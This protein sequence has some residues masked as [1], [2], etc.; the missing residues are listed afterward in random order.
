MMTTMTIEQALI[1]AVEAHK[2]R[3]LQEAE[4]LYRAIL[5]NQPNQ[6]DANHNLGILAVQTGHAHSALSYLK[7]ALEANPSQGQFWIDYID[8]LNRT[9]QIQAA[10]SVLE[11]G[12]T[13]GLKG[14]A[15][16]R[17]REKFAANSEKN[18]GQNIIEKAAAFREA[19]HYEKSRELLTGYLAKNP[20][21]AEA[22]AHLSHVHLLLQ[23]KDLAFE[24]IDRAVKINPEL[25][26]VQQNLSRI[27]LGRGEVLQAFEAA[28]KACAKDGQDHRNQL[29]LASCLGQ[30]Q[31]INEAMNLIDRILAQQPDFAEAFA[32]RAVFLQRQGRTKEAIADATRALELNPHIPGLYVFTAGLYKV[33]KDMEKA[34]ALL[35][36]AIQL[37]PSDKAA[38]G[39]K[40]RLLTETDK[41][42]A[43]ADCYNELLKTE[44]DNMDNLAQTG[45]VYSMMGQ[46]EKARFF[47]DK[48]IQA[49]STGLHGHFY[50]GQH[51]LRNG[52]LERAEGFFQKVL[53]FPAPPV[54]VYLQCSLIKAHKKDFSAALKLVEEGL[55]KFPNHS[56]LISAFSDYVRCLPDGYDLSGSLWGRAHSRLAGIWEAFAQKTLDNKDVVCAFY[57]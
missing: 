2:N 42:E 56:G 38:C 45:N 39:Q 16:N 57:L 55:K 48:A 15:V 1:Q 52:E 46:N 24:K 23:E 19:G 31:K 36:V 25:A 7:T 30:G 21:D 6:P 20:D 34:L 13:A 32:Q 50:Q 10:K 17:L 53:A 51:F 43:A 54:E 35:D 41:L 14:E 33:V 49:D 28:Q 40:A 4:Q 8:T 26:I 37:H 29:V 11:Q 12:L 3:N 47:L 44:P 18:Q 22:L 5:Q 9:G 27:L